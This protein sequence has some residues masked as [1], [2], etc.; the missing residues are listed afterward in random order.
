MDAHIDT[1]AYHP[2]FDFNH[3]VYT[4]ALGHFHNIAHEYSLPDDVVETALHDACGFLHLDSAVTR[5]SRWVFMT[6][7]RSRLSVR[8]R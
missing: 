7:S 4:D 2:T 1:T 6:N 8:M 3:A 5:C